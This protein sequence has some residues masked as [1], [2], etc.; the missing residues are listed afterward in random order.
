MEMFAGAAS[1]A[2][3][4]L[5]TGPPRAARVV[6]V[7]PSCVYVVAGDELVALES[8]DA[9]GLPCSVRLGVDRS[10]APFTGVRLGDLAAVGGGTV[11]A[12]PL[13]VTVGRWWAPRQPRR[14]L[15]TDD[16]ETRARMD[17]AAD[18][19]AT[20][21]CPVPVDGSVDELLGLGPG[22]TPAGDDVLAGLL[23]GLRHH[24]ALRR[25][26]SDGV[27][28]LAGE[29]TTTLS[30]ALLRY[31][32]TGLALPAVVGV[33]D[34]LAGHGT[35][36]DLARAVTRLVAVGHSSGTAL[37]HGVLRGARTVQRTVEEAA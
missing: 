3:R 11:V 13:T 25:P 33:A 37:A 22:L 9:L 24:D 35:D 31:A 7:H 15:S 5:L 28:R 17:L 14:P 21:A 12:G 18:V 6:G 26:F 23:V 2:I 16:S 8:A 19:L 30:A 1:V 32:A 20:Q 29:R 10:D 34:A 36:A 27:V 4:D